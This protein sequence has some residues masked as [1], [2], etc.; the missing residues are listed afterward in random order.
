MSSPTLQHV[1][2]KFLPLHTSI[3]FPMRLV[4]LTV[5]GKV[6]ASGPCRL[7]RTGG[8]ALKWFLCT[9]LQKQCGGLHPRSQHLKVSAAV[10]SEYP[11]H[12]SKFVFSIS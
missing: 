8:Q 3:F 10:M 4:C 9:D 6:V 2:S 7:G 1:V 11:Q 5:R 12:R